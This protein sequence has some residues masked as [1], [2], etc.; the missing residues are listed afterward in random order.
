[1]YTDTSVFTVNGLDI[2][3]FIQSDGLK[4]TINSSD[5]STAGRAMNGL[6]YR[7]LICYKIT[8]SVT[9]MPMSRTD[10]DA[11]LAAVMPEFFS[12]TVD[13]PGFGEITRE[14]YA[15][16]MPMQVK[17]FVRSGVQMYSGV[18]L[19]LVER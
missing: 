6:M 16:K 5:G 15:A 4:F 11:L 7:D 18:T 8:I 2:L 19:S 3:P 1:M 10:L 17:Q 12:V 9:C 13:V 14:F